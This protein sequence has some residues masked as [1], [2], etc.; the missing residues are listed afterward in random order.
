MDLIPVIDLMRGQVIRGHAGQREHYR[1][2]VSHLVASADP[3]QTCQALVRHFRPHII[4]IA[5]LD[6]I[7]HQQPQL[8]VLETLARCDVDLAVD[9]GTA[10]LEQALALIRIGVRKVIVALETLPEMDR[11]H[12]F[13]AVLGAEHVLFSLDLLNGDPMGPQGAGRSPIEV[14]SDAIG[15]GVRQ[16]ITLELS[17]VGTNRGVTTGGLCHTIKNRWPDLVIWTGGGVRSL[18]DLHKLSLSR[19]DGAMVA[20]ALH[21]GQITGTDWKNFQTLSNDS[22]QMAMDA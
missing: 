10:S 16:M 3:L 19:V 21:D 8:D 15:C 12:E 17:H 6:G 18:A 5:D 14:V 1:P 4:Y 20:S 9:A 2:N 22:T 7:Q 11:L 13:V